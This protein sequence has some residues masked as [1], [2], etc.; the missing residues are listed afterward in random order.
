[1]YDKLFGKEWYEI[2]KDYLYSEEFKNIGLEVSKQ[3]ESEKVLPPK[4]SPLYFKIFKDLQPSKIK[5]IILGMD[6]YPQEG[7]YTGYA[8]DNAN[9][10][11]LSPSLRNIF[12]EIERTYPENKEEL[13]LDGWDL[14]RWV[15]QGVF[16]INT[17]LTVIE[18]SPGSHLA[19]WRPFTIEWIKR[20]SEY[21]NDLIWLLWGSKAHDFSQYINNPSHYII[22]T[23]HP[24][25]LNRSNPFIG[26]NCFV[27]A[28]EQLKGLNK[29]E[30][31]W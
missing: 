6:P 31:L 24:S 15:V 5:V 16:L 2:L 20:L 22:K 19:L 26:S 1:M 23:G 4:G 14:K 30:I 8:F 21:R 11:K 12:K 25:P 9:S 7:I 13:I 18:N 17:A 29:T 27:E 10:T 28:N 3:Y